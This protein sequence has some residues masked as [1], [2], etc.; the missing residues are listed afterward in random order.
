MKVTIKADETTR[1]IAQQAL[2]CQDA[3]NMRGLS[4]SF[5]KMLD[6]ID[7]ATGHGTDFINQHPVTKLW[8]DKF[9]S[10]ARL[11]QGSWSY[12]GDTDKRI[13]DSADA[14]QACSALARGEDV[15]WKVIGHREFMTV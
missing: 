8:I 3:C 10:L 7:T 15:E 4:K 1:R 5:A 12:A 11:P 2:D 9:Q 13:P 6:E 14:W